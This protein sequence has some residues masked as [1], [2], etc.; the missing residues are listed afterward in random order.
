MVLVVRTVSLGAIAVRDFL[1]LIDSGGSFARGGWAGRIRAARSHQTH[2][3]ERK[4][5]SNAH[6]T[7][8]F[9][10]QGKD[11]WCGAGVQKSGAAV[12]VEV[13]NSLRRLRCIV[14]LSGATKGTDAR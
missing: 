12:C 5:I 2:R 11:E 7:I 3:T 6:R 4:D 9:C 1:A 13:A 14:A 10:T 8:A